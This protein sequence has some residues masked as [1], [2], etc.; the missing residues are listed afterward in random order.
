MGVTTGR[1]TC[2]HPAE[3]ELTAHGW[4]Y[5]TACFDSIPNNL[6]GSGVSFLTG[7]TNGWFQNKQ[8]KVVM[9][10]KTVFSPVQL[11]IK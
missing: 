2:R 10:R 9:E 8:K 4:N 1:V 5:S 3:T 11:T 7:F 6:Q